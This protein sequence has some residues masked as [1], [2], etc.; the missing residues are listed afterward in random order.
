MAY[1]RLV[2]AAVFAALMAGSAQAQTTSNVG[3]RKKC[4][5][6]FSTCSKRSKSGDNVCLRT[7]HRC[8]T[9]CTAAAAA[10]PAPAKGTAMA[11]QQGKRR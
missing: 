1:K 4:D 11:A 10:K 8:K 2:A 9:Q 7:W 6:S 3:C 5:A